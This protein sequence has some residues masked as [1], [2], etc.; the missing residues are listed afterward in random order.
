M[1]IFSLF[2]ALFLFLALASEWYLARRQA[3]HVLA[4]RGAVP[5]RFAARV[6][7][8]AH[9]KAADY[10]LAR[11]GFGRWSQCWNVVLLVFWTWGGGLDMLDRLFRAFGWSELSTGVWVMLCFFILG[12]LLEIP[13]A[14]WRT[15]GI[16]QRFGFN[17]STPALFFTDLAKQLLLLLLIGL[18]LAWIVLRLMQAMGTLWWLY[19]WF[20]WAGFSLLMLWVYPTWIAPWFNRF[21]PLPDGELKTRIRALLQRCG[22]RSRGLFVMDA[23]RRST[24]GNAYFTGMGR[25]KRIV[26]FDT[27]LDTLDDDEILAVLAHELGHLCH[28]HVRKRLLL[29]IAL[30]FAGFALLGWLAGQPWFY[31][32]LGVSRPSA[33]MALLLFMLAMPVFLFWSAPLM[34]MLSR[35]HEFEADAFA[36]RHASAEKLIS[37][38]VKMYAENAATL[39]PDPW[40]SA[41]HD[42]H[43]PAP[44][45]IARL[46]SMRAER[47]VT[48]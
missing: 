1:T 33:H 14:W 42:S 41:W 23:S 29:M 37:A 32:S 20:V 44:I 47:E 12:Q 39:T 25:A 8:E 13:F 36:T 35:R 10:T 15:F 17:R 7:L 28:G 31:S 26:F 5:E 19:A 22:F 9:Q 46:E 43:P 11:L 4:H 2:F 24:H 40:F 27:L 48:Q 30:S 3:R 18:P 21:R 16:E 34:N 38:L 45:R 6:S